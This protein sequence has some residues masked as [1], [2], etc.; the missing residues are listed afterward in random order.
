MDT[1]IE[2][3]VHFTSAMG[4]SSVVFPEELVTVRTAIRCAA[5]LDRHRL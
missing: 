1:I 4:K 5:I 2:N 3:Y